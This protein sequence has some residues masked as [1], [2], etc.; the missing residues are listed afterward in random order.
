MVGIAY[1]IQPNNKFDQICLQSICS[2]FTGGVEW[3]GSNSE[4]RQIWSNLINIKPNNNVYYFRTEEQ[5]V[6]RNELLTVFQKLKP[7]AE[8]NCNEAQ[9]SCSVLQ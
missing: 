6:Q 4:C 3:R 7:S 8:S 5:K 2:P 1:Y 9:V